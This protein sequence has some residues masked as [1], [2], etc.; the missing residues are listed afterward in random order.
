MYEVG[1]IHTAA[2]LM[3][4]GLEFSGLGD[5][6]G[7]RYQFVFQDPDGRGEALLMAHLSGTLQINSLDGMNRLQGLKT[8]IY[9]ERRKR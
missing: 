2:A 3:A 7:G 1:D 9:T 4:A 8:L 5:E 6:G